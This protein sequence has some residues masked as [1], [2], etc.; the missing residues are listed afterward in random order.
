MTVSALERKTLTDIS[1]FIALVYEKFWHEA[2]LAKRA[3]YNDLRVL[4]LL[5]D[6]TFNNVVRDAAMAVFKRHL[7]NFSEHLVQL[8]FSTPA[9]MTQIFLLMPPDLWQIDP[10]YI[11]FRET[12]RHMKVVNDC[13]EREVTLIQT[14][15]SY[16]TKDEKQK[17]D[18][19]QVLITNRKAFPEPSKR[20][21]KKS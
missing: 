7:R 2:R 18:L 3:Q 13:A 4:R 11:Q 1:L 16:I 15:N 12:A 14:F 17:Q 21:L 20:L 9:L 8:A 5:N 6:Y 19:L 10:I